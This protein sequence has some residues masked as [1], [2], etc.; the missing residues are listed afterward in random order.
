[1]VRHLGTIGLTRSVLLQSND[2]FGDDGAVGALKGFELSGLKPVLHISCDRTKPD[3]TPVAPQ[4]A[5]A[6]RVHA[7]ARGRPH[8]HAHVLFHCRGSG[9][10]DLVRASAKVRSRPTMPLG[11]W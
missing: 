4:V 3:F 6:R 1:M 2:S 8:G 10:Q 5:A 7:R 11:K 9:I